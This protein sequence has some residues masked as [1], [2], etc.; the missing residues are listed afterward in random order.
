MS[1]SARPVLK[2]LRP[3]SVLPLVPSFLLEL[4]FATRRT[5]TAGFAYYPVFQ[6]VITMVE[7]WICLETP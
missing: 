4:L 6:P 3:P 1:S 2:I 7:V 5:L